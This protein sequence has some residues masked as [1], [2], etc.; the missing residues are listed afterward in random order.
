MTAK[1]FMQEAIALARENIVN[2]GRPFGAV[3]VKDGNIIARAVNRMTADNDPT[4]HAEIVALRKAGT[5]LA[6]DRLAGCSVYASGQPCP[7]CLAAMH[8]AGI[9]EIIFGYSNESGAPYGLSTAAAAAVLSLPV[10]TQ[11][12]AVIR[13]LPPEDAATPRIYQSWTARSTTDG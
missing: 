4:A 2:G 11:D 9:T 1:A 12:W 8:L 3:I 6:T 13:H 5:V 7:M 10:D